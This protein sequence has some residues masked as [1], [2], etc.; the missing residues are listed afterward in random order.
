MT[1]TISDNVMNALAYIG[2]EYMYGI[3]EETVLESLIEEF[4]YDNRDSKLELILSGEYEEE[5]EEEW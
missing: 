4:A 2:K 3:R 1:F 5:E